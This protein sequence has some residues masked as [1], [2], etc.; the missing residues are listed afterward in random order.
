[1]SHIALIA[2]FIAAFAIA[3]L[4]TAIYLLSKRT[5]PM[6]V[7]PSFQPVIDEI[8]ALTTS[9]AALKAAAD[10]AS[11]APSAQDVTDTEA[12][13]QTAADGLKAAAGQ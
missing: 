10:A 11:G 8:N 4:P 2:M 13:L 12:A 7:I 5:A 1:M 6:P 3:N 9:V